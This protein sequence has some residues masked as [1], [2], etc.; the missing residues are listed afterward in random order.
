MKYIFYLFMIVANLLF[1]SSCVKEVVD[2]PLRG[3]WRSEVESHSE[4]G[5]FTMK[6]IFGDEQMMRTIIEFVEDDSQMISHEK[7][8]TEG[9]QLLLETYKIEG[10]QDGVVVDTENDSVTS[11]YRY[12]LL[13]PEL[14]ELTDVRG[15]KEVVTLRRV[16]E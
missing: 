4:M 10:V 5:N 7:Y 2:M 15:V 11:A 3:V 12:R 8:R 16:K 9:D 14:L 6:L 1:A 13:N